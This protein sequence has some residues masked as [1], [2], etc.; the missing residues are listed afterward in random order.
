M[1]NEYLSDPLVNLL[2]LLY[3]FYGYS[4]LVFK[5]ILPVTPFTNMD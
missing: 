3:V 4:P 1:N 5:P 2:L